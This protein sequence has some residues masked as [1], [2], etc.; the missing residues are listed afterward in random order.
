MLVELNFF[1]SIKKSYYAKYLTRDLL[2]ANTAVLIKNELKKIYNVKKG[3]GDFLKK[4]FNKFP[5]WVNNFPNVFNYSTL[6][7]NY[8]YSIVKSSGLSVCPFCNEEKINIVIGRNK[9][10]R[11][12]LDHYLPRSKYPFLS[13]SLYNLI[14]VGKRCNSHFKSDAD[15]SEGYMNPLLNGLN[16]IPLFEFNYN[17]VSDTVDFRIK[18]YDDFTL[19]QMLFEID[20]VYLTQ[21]FKKKYKDFRY[22]YIYNKGLGDGTPFYLNKE[23]MDATFNISP[24]K[25]LFNWPSKKF[26][27]DAIED[28][29]ED[30]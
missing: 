13:V 27:L 19:N 30:I 5:A 6:S 3:K 18:D 15:M 9:S 8:G 10:S 17:I 21:A 11:P 14:P 28:I 29:F 4:N 12:D 22:L 16:D 7:K 2:L 1:Q 24:D 25:N 20:D 23:L 26:E